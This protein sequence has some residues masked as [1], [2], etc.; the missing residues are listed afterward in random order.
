MLPL[1]AEGRAGV[2]AR[3]RL[4]GGA[5]GGGV[6]E[7]WPRAV[8]RAE[9]FRSVC[10]APNGAPGATR[11]SQQIREL[12]SVLTYVAIWSFHSVFQ[13]RTMI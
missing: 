4:L 2:G 3:A 13:G 9:G 5:P 10:H 12:E 1:R 7:L 11:L 6:A 8:R